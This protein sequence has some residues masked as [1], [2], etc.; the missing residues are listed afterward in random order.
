MTPN[1]L[2]LLRMPDHVDFANP[3]SIG[4]TMGVSGSSLLI[5][6]LFSGCIHKPY[7]SVEVPLQGGP[8]CYDSMGKEIPCTEEMNCHEEPPPKVEA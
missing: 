5:L 8:T 1:L 2:K 6:L 7:P 3:T 4:R